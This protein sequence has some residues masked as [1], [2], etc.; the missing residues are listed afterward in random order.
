MPRNDKIIDFANTVL[1][2][3]GKEEVVARITE[4][5][6]TRFHRGTME[7]RVIASNLMD[8]MGLFFSELHKIVDEN[9][10]PDP[11]ETKI[12]DVKR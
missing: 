3:K 12:E 5:L 9:A 6:F 4:S 2:H 10:K 11:E 8:S 7:E 1:N